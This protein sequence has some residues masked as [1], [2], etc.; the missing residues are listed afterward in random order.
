MPLPRAGQEWPP[1]PLASITG[2]YA[3][4]DAWYVGDPE[5]LTRIYG[6]PAVGA[7]FEDRVSQHRGGVVGAVARFWWGKPR[8]R[9]DSGDPD[10]LHV[11]LAGDICQASADLLYAEP[12]TFTASTPAGQQLIDDALE[13]GLI[14]TLAGGAET[15][16]ALGDVYQRV[17]WDTQ[18][19]PSSFITT[20][21]ADAA[22]PEFRW[23]QLVA[24]TFWWVLPGSD[25]TTVRRH[26]ERH[27]LDQAG[28]GV[29]LHGLYE[30][31]PGN[32]GRL[33]PLPEDPDT[34]ALATLVDQ[35]G[36]IATLS[37]GLA[38][39]RIPNRG[40]QR[41]WR[42]HPLGSHLGRSDLDTLEPLFDKLDFVYSSWMRDVRLAK[43]RLIVP[44]YM[45]QSEGRGTGAW[46][47]SDQDVFTTVNAPPREDGGA[48]QITAQQFAIRVADHL[49][50]AQEL[51]ETILRTAGYSAATFG[52][53]ESDGGGVTA[54][55]VV[56]RDRRSNLTR[57]RKI[58]EAKPALTRLLAKK[59]AVDRAVLGL[60]VEADASVAV[61]FVDVSQA[62]PESLAR[63]SLA[64]FQA[65]AASTD[66]RV[67]L[68]HPDWDEPTVAAEVTR[69]LSEF[70]VQ[71]P[72]PVSFRPGVDDAVD[73]AAAGVVGSQGAGQP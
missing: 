43:S 16:A 6:G 30:G 13:S 1:K 47:D 50:T 49:A 42:G 68:Q 51:V 36:A 21:H 60:P 63:T 26:L 9:V 56:S 70:S 57:D 27:E 72:D 66:T 28:N 29:V 41:R 18:H 52:E 46:F 3:E 25:K 44:E 45:L 15:A 48:S 40:P 12:P 61:A 62:D 34:A 8:G 5:R 23:G 22:H 33:I 65:Q 69:I 73:Q 24:V 4:W 39:V 37:P 35:D 14:G 31:T 7:R 55:E 71:V 38:V 58:R 20:M 64:L 32:L 59:L 67:R 54:T 53:A 2:K 11:P 19:A 10:K 17:T